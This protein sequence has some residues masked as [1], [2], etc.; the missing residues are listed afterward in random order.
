[1]DR[2]DQ[3]APERSH[4]PAR[5]LSVPAQ[6]EWTR[7]PDVGPGA[8]VL[9]PLAGRTVIEL[10]CGSGRNLAH[11]VGVRHAIGIGI[12]RD[13]AKI[14]R[15]RQQY[16]HLSNLS[17]VLGDAAAVLTSMPP[18]AADVCLSIF[19]AFSFSPPGPLLCAATRALRPGG[20]L[21]I[22]LRADD[23]HD[24]VIVFVRKNTTAA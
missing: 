23:H 19:G 20:R 13:P 14:T 21:A 12:D 18:S 7:Q 2:H 11:L 10:G 22:I 8:S 9:G 16:G 4:C 5:H 24:H 15:A 6:L 1:M 3:P 17:F